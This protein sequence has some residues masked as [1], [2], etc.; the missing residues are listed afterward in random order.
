MQGYIK[1]KYVNGNEETFN[2]DP[3]IVDERMLAKRMQDLLSLPALV[4]QLQ[5][6]FLFI[7]FANIESISFSHPRL[8]Q[9]DISIPLAIAATRN[10]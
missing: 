8:A 7:P 4:F 5:E 3:K 9:S 1:I 10:I 6:S 2:F